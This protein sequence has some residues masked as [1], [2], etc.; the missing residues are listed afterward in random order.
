MWFLQ[1]S[2]CVRLS[3]RPPLS[4]SGLVC[5][6][7]SS[8]HVTGA[9]VFVAVTQGTPLDYLALETR[10]ACIPGPMG[11]YKLEAVFGRLPAPRHCMDRRL[12]TLSFFLSK[13]LGGLSWTFSTEDKLQVWHTSRSLLK[14]P[15]CTQ[16]GPWH[17]HTLPLHH[18]NSLVSPRKLLHTHLEP[19][20]LQLLPRRYFHIIWLWQPAGLLFEVP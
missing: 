9:L 1:V 5:G 19:S 17:L 10:G 14:C 3:R 16:A 6:P 11:L 8:T 13:R 18:C 12:N 2:E 7:S 4:F 20:F 15:Q